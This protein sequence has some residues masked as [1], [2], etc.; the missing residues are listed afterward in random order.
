MGLVNRRFSQRHPGDLPSHGSSMGTPTPGGHLSIPKISVFVWR[1]ALLYICTGETIMRC[2]QKWIVEVNAEKGVIFLTDIMS[3]FLFI[4]M[5]HHEN[6][7]Q[8]LQASLYRIGLFNKWFFNVNQCFICDIILLS[9]LLLR[10][11]Y[12]LVIQVYIYI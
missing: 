10:I 9:V 6:I 8:V 3:K 12:Y 4:K 2:C 5:H 7:M 11:Y 1:P